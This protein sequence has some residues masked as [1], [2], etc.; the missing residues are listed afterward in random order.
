MQYQI[1]SSLSLAALG[2]VFVLFFI[3]I[4]GAQVM[5]SPSYQLQ[6]DSA[7]SGGGLS[8]SNIYIQ[9]STVGEVGTGPSE[10]AEFKLQAGYQQLGAVTISLSTPDNV[11]MS[12]NIGGVTGGTSNGSTTVTVT[13]DSPAGY[14]L[15][16]EAENDPA[17]WRTDMSESIADYVPSGVP[18][19]VFDTQSNDAHFGYSPTGVDTASEF[20]DNTS[21]C[22]VGSANTDLACW[23]GL[24]T[25]AV[26]ISEGSSSN[27]PSGAITTINFRVGL[28]GGVVVS[29]GVY[30][31][32]TTLTAIPL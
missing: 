26:V 7:N 19:F 2:T 18:D 6:Q 10:S 31:A 29:E 32:T 15:T 5:S 27:Q 25:S 14:Q 20:L 1:S 30:I 17:M 23:D 24:T 3:Q 9:E 13:T 21:A 11:I 16:I 12:G 4:A 8:S 22:G 28:G